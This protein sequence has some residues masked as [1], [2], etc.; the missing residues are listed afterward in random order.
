MIWSTRP[1]Y[2]ALPFKIEIRD[3]SVPEF[4][5]LFRR[6]CDSLGFPWRPEVVQQLIE[7]Y[8]KQ[9]NRPLRRCYAR[10]LLS[11]VR[12]YCAYRSEPLDLRLDYLQHACRNYFGCLS[13]NVLDQTSSSSE[14][15]ARPKSISILENPQ[16]GTHGL[17]GMMNATH[18]LGLPTA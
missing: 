11:Q 4:I 10:D 1:F 7:G 3:P 14:P 9:V 8:F 18:Q 2:G 6:G 13:G 12:A 5:E 17:D 15:G 16:S